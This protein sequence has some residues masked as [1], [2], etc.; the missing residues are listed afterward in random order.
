MRTHHK[1]FS[2]L[3]I[4]LLMSGAAFWFVMLNPW[5]HPWP[6][7]WEAPEPGSSHQV[8]VYGTLTSPLL[9]WVV[10]GRAGQG[11][12]RRLPGY[13]RQGLDIAA[14]PDAELDGLLLQVSGAE[15]QRLDRYERLGLRYER[16]LMTL[17]DGSKAW[18]YRRL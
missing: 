1:A 18:V 8:F 4:L 6:V 7:D 15:L 3:L 10:K 13:E 9:R 5:N 12:P 11:E 17:S 2:A 14:N 16:Q